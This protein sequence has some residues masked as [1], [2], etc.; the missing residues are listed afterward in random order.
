MPIGLLNITQGN[1][2]IGSWVSP[3][4]I[5]TVGH[6]VPRESFRAVYSTTPCTT[7]NTQV[8]PAAGFAI[9]GAIWYQ[10]EANGK[11]GDGYYWKIKAL[12]E[13]WRKVWNQGEFPFYDVQLPSYEARKA[14]WP[15]LREAQRKAL[16]IPNTGLVVL[17]DAGDTSA[18][19]PINLHPRNKYVVGQRLALW[20]L[21][22][23]YGKKDL[24]H[25][26]PLFKAAEFKDGK[27]IVSFDH[28]GGG[29]MAARKSSSRSVEPPAPVE[30]VV[31]FETAGANK[32]WSAAKAG[33]QGNQIVLTPSAVNKP[34]AVRYLYTLNT[35]H[36]TLYNKEGLPASP[37]RTDDWPQ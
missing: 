33:I 35:D 7:Y 12:I 20:A 22:H 6:K 10:G 28:V 37:F 2:R 23:D 21:A 4:S 19:F 24:V 32:A 31:G 15:P 9:K 36:G 26:G 14:W 1:T 8:S 25:S 30:E 29:L 17:T 3:E 11:D 34:V 16:T 27:A 5:A 13:G 18:E